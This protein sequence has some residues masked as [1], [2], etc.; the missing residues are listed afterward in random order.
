M[1]ELESH[2]PGLRQADTVVGH[3]WT[4]RVPAQALQPRPIASRDQHAGVQIE[5]A[6]PRMT[7]PP[8]AGYGQS[9]Q[10]GR[11]AAAAHRGAGPRP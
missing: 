5:A 9:R 2:V 7:W 1:P 3:G 11:L 6:P 8:L 4:E 10:I